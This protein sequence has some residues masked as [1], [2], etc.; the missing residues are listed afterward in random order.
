MIEILEKK[1]VEKRL[2]YDELSDHFHHLYITIARKG[3]TRLPIYSGDLSVALRLR[4]RVVKEVIERHFRELRQAYGKSVYT[5]RNK[6]QGGCRAMNGYLLPFQAAMQV[7]P[8]LPSN[9]KLMHVPEVL[10]VLLAG[11]SGS[12][13]YN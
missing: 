10:Y 5:V 1:S 9:T 8:Y 3:D 13:L 7:L 2:S 12:L 11:E 4:H 6:R